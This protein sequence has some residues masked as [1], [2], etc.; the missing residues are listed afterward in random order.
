MARRGDLE[1]DVG[2]NILP[3]REMQRRYVARVYERLG[4]R[5]LL[6]GERLGIDDETLARW[7]SREPSDAAGL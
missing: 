6:A 3:L 7:L 4:S 2:R 5:K 1:I